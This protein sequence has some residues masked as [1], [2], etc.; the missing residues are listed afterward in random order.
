MEL[1]PGSP[2]AFTTLFDADTDSTLTSLFNEGVG[3]LT[4]NRYEINSPIST[5]KDAEVAILILRSL[6]TNIEGCLW[7]ERTDGEFNAELIAIT[8]YQIFHFKGVL[9]P[10][11]FLL[12]G[13]T[14]RPLDSI[15]DSCV[16]TTLVMSG[17]TVC[18]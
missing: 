3:I 14:A 4:V 13:I 6:S 18:S 15:L 12:V 5:A 7:I 17:T 1:G 2:A 10:R 16:P 9:F 11:K 8:H